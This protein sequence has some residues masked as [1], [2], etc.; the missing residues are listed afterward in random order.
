MDKQ[1]NDFLKQLTPETISSIV[2][3]AQTTLDDSREEFKENPSTNLGNQVCVISTWISLGL[4]EE[5]HE[6][7][8]K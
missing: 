2:N 3:K 7:L 4:L 6:W 5:Y 1:F 8:Q